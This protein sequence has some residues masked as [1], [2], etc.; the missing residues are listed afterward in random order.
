MIN[1]L[2]KFKS[3]KFLIMRYKYIYQYK[4]IQSKSPYF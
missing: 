1:L 2:E 3:D 4:W